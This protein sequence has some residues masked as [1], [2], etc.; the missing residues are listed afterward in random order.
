MTNSQAKNFLL[1]VNMSENKE[2]TQIYR[3]MW[4]GASPLLA[5]NEILID[6]YLS[7]RTDTRRGITLLIRITSPVSESIQKFLAEVSQVEPGQYAYPSSDLHVTVMSVLSCI[8]DYTLAGENEAAY[9]DLIRPIVA[10]TPPFS[11]EFSG[12]TLSESG[13]VLCGYPSNNSLNQLRDQLRQHITKS[14]LPH[15]MDARYPLITAHSTV[16]RFKQRLQDPDKLLVFLAKNRERHF[17]Q[18]RVRNMALV[19]NDWYQ[20]QSTT[21]L[22]D[23]LALKPAQSSTKI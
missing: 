9:I 22:M 2:I 18:L 5:R 10:N 20:S 4:Q 15:S 12:L 14:A 19:V 23:T 21:V 8:E 11:I 16:L 1:S 17:G 6:P 3:N 7:G 13:I